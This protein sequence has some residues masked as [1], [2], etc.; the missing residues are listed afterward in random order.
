MARHIVVLVWTSSGGPAAVDQQYLHFVPLPSF[1]FDSVLSSQFD[2]AS[3][4]AT[5]VA[6]VCFSHYT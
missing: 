6:V 3:G 4:G 2:D 5:A 1:V